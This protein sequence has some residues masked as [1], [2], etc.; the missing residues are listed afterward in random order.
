MMLGPAGP[1]RIDVGAFVVAVAG[2]GTDAEVHSIR[3]FIDHF[4]VDRIVVGRIDVVERETEIVHAHGIGYITLG[5]ILARVAEHWSIPVHVDRKAQDAWA[6]DLGGFGG[7][8]AGL[9]G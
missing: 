3:A 9:E 1:S 4:H 2:R 6:D 8:I 5:I 7:K